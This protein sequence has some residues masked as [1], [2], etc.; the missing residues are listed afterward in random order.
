MAYPIERKLVVGV[1]STALFNLEYEDNIYNSEGIEAYKKYQN[2]NKHKP[3]EKGVAYP[4]IRR[5]LHIND[6]FPDQKPVEV[7]ILSKK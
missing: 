2:E 7:V 4:F 5:F 3:L 6:S 1:S